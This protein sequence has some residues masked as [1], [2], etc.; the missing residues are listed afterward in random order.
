VTG[1]PP[2]DGSQIGGLAVSNNTNSRLL[3]YPSPAK[4]DTISKVGISVI[5][6]QIIEAGKISAFMIYYPEGFLNAI[7]IPSELIVTNSTP[8][9]VTAIDYSKE[10]FLVVYI[11]PD[12]Q[13]TPGQFTFTFPVHVP[14]QVPAKNLWFLCVCDE[15]SC[16]NPFDEGVLTYFPIAGFAIGQTNPLTVT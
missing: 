4:S 13:I 1:D 14:P 7:S 10:S 11:D 9:T 12:Q 8:L 6:N 16:T 2:F 15:A 5:S 3:W